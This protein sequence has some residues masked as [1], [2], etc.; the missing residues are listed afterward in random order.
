MKNSLTDEPG[1]DNLRSYLKT[2]EAEKYIFRSFKESSA[3]V[4]AE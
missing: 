1:T 3:Q 2:S 4:E